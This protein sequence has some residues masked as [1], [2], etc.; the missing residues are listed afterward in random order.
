MLRQFAALGA[1]L[2]LANAFG[3]SQTPIRFVVGTSA[4]SSADLVARLLAVRLAQILN[5]PVI[6]DNKP[7]AATRLAN[8]EV[9]RSAPDG[10]TLLF[11]P[12]GT[13]SV[14]PHLYTPKN[15]GYVPE[16]F[17]PVGRVSKFDYMLAV[18]PGVK[19]TNLAELKAWLKANPSLASIA[20]PGTGTIPN[21]L[22]I[23]LAKH[24]DVDLQHI[25]YRGTAPAAQDLMGGHVSLLIGTNVELVTL[26]NSGKL[27][28]L[29]S[30]T[31]SR[32]PAFPDVSTLTEMGEPLAVD[33]LH[34]VWAP[35]GTPQAAID[36]F[37]AAL[38]KVLDE[39]AVKVEFE[40]LGLQ[41]MP[42]TPA[43]LRRV[44]QEDFTRW[45]TFIKQANITMTE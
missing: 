10:N 19:A 34:G 16:D 30:I 17:V 32:S 29:A 7:G 26:H 44:Q 33:S 2:P 41:A 6:V 22:S 23:V 1:A 38:K 40:K 14:L 21:L 27:R 43:G 24:L 31:E 8:A 37:G 45:G 39:P 4:G 11:S 35:A 5:R 18:G 36:N 15:L 9:K 25:A 42:S 13:F 12:V 20:N 28:V 3:Q